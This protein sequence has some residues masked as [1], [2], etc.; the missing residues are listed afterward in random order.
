MLFEDSPIDLSSWFA[1]AHPTMCRQG[2]WDCLDYLDE[3]KMGEGMR[4]EAIEAAKMKDPEVIQEGEDDRMDD[5]FSDF[6][7]EERDKVR[8]DYHFTDSNALV[9]VC[10][11][12]SVPHF[13][14]HHLK[15]F[16]S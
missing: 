1:I 7:K 14:F 10:P 4:E 12:P 2:W 16:K 13:L 9:R 15:L 6:E 8:C 3:D 5:I 11:P